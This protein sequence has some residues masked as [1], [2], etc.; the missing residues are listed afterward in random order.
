MSTRYVVIGAGAVGALLAAQLELAG[1]PVV[2]VARGVHLALIR[3]QG[4]TIHRPDSID[5][6]RPRAVDGPAGVH[7]TPDDVLVLAV[8][9]QDADAAL[10]EWAWQPV[11]GGGVTADLPILTFQNGMDTEALALRRFARVY[12]VTIAVAASYLTPG[13]V[14]SPSYP[15]IGVVWIGRYPDRADPAADGFAEDLRRAGYGARSVPD[16]TA[17]K[18][19]KLLGNVRNGLDLLAGSAPD[20]ARAGELLTA[21]ASA[22]FAAEGI[23]PAEPLSGLVVRPVPGHTPGRLS[24]WQSHARGASSETD[25][26]NGEIVLRGRRLGVPTP[27][28]ARLQR[29]VGTSWSSGT[30]YPVG[31][32]LTV[33]DDG[34]PGGTRGEDGPSTGD[35]TTGSPS[36]GSPAP[37]AARNGA[38]PAAGGAEV[39]ISA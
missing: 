7:L 32:L 30:T 34:P 2:L 6:V 17:W 31:E 18:A 23:V 4:L 15:R 5:T 29:L 24:T 11:A 14:V 37:D 9:A 20:K 21:E 26:L 33:I 1:I 35:T 22:V 38:G 3:G 28:N 10:A 13:A 36:A 27:V 19:R 25:H 8:K 16:I 39:R 12:G